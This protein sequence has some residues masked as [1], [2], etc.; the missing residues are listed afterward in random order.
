VSQIL[1]RVRKAL[2]GSFIDARLSADPENSIIFRA[3]QPLVGELS[4]V[5]MLQDFGIFDVSAIMAGRTQVAICVTFRDNVTAK[6][7]QGDHASFV[8]DRVKNNLGEP[9]TAMKTN[10]FLIFGFSSRGALILKK[11][12]NGRGYGAV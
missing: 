3:R 6:V 2:P 7:T 12:K 5:P 11:L 10:D 4:K 9:Y 1:K 8:S